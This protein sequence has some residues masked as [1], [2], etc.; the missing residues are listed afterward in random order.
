[1][2]RVPL[3]LI[4]GGGLGLLDGLS[5]FLI[6][7]ARGMMT[8]IIVWG[9]AKGLVTGLL[10]GV[11]ACRVE[12]VGKNVLAGGAVGAVLSLLAAI[13]TGSYVEIVPTGIV[14]GL[15]AGLIVSKWGK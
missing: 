6:P 1:M 3:G 7:E 14:I 8:E 11:I 9:T 2:K 12:G 10:V 4:A 5:A 13:S 15:L